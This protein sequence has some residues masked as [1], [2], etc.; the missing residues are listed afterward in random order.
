MLVVMGILAILI[1]ASIAGFSHAT[2]KARSSL[3][4]ELVHN[5]A[6]ALE[7]VLQDEDGWPQRILQGASGEG[8]MTDEVGG[9]LARRKVLSLTYRETTND[10]DEK[11]YKLVGLDQCG[12]VSPS[13]RDVIK[14]LAAKGSVSLS[15][16]V[17]S[18]GKIDDHILRYAVDDDLDGIVNVNSQGGGVAVRASVAVWCCGKDGKFGTRDDIKSWSKGQ[19][20]SR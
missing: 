16:R 9:E 7:K 5:V 19:E 2:D 4:Q 12:V 3:C 6:T 8:K 13:A 15:A 17:P 18:G 10:K 11:V 20:K 1:G 14:R